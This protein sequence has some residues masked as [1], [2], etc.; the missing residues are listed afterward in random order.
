VGAGK[1]RR[2]DCRAYLRLLLKIKASWQA[3]N[4]ESRQAR[5]DGNEKNINTEKPNL[6]STHLFLQYFHFS[7]LSC[8]LYSY[9]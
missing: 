5:Y 4:D 7:K 6:Y 1:N 9:I 8:L 3:R 2:W